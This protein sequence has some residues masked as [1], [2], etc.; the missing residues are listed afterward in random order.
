VET[1]TAPRAFK[2][3][4][5]L[6]FRVAKQDFAIEA[7]TVRAILPLHQMASLNE[8]HHWIQGF[9]NLS[10]RDF[11]VVDL[12]EKLGIEKGSQ[13]RQPCILAVES[14]GRIAGFIADRVSEV[15]QLRERDFRHGAVRNHGR[16]RR[17]LD[18]DQILTEN[19]WSELLTSL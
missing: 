15:L 10:G 3:G 17:L 5:Y 4:Q 9:A 11:P 12:R 16:A 8:P 13:G 2:P 18:P 14:N 6:T 1:A 7:S 19:E